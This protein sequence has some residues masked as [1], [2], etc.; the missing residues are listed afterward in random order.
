MMMETL[1]LITI[2]GLSVRECG[3][4]HA[5]TICFLHG[6]GVSG[7]MWRPQIAALQNIYHCLIPDLPEHGLSAEVGPFT[8]SDAASRIAELIRE[9]AHGGRAHVIG[10]S[11]GAQVTIQLLGSKP[12]VVD[13]AVISS[14]LLHP[15]PGLGLLG[16]AALKL[17][18]R[19]SVAP[20]QGSESYVRL[21]MRGNG[22][23]LQYFNE[24]R[25]DT[26]RMTAASFSHMLL[27]NQR[28][29]LPTGLDQ[30]RVPTL[31]VA[32]QHELALMRRSVRD[33]VAV[34]PAGQGYLVSF[35][36]RTAEEHSWNLHR[37]DLFN[38]VVRAWL[39]DQ[40]LPPELLAFS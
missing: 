7:W 31:V 35:S 8:I 22:L 14:A 15:L 36:K 32:G 20:F 19:L 21:N 1:P 33:L 9:R 29:R 6:G 17:I 37:P 34:L 5:S 30:V 13:H 16:P 10:L 12:E 4:D 23:P 18:F 28:F 27:E 25:E 11:Q 38:A 3:P 2:A 26:K 40:P 39:S 24:V